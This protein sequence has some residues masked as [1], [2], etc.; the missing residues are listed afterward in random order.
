MAIHTFSLSEGTD[1]FSGTTLGVMSNL[2]ARV[3]DLIRFIG[4]SPT[5]FHATVSLTERLETRGFTRLLM[6]D[7]WEELPAQ[8]FVVVDGS[9]IAWRTPRRWSSASTGLRIIASHTDSPALKVKPNAGF[10][11][12]DSHQVGVEVY[13]GPQLHTWIDRDLCLAGR[14]VDID[15]QVH[16][17]HTQAFARVP[18]LAIHLDRGQR[19]NFHID[20]A[21]DINVLISQVTA[22]NGPIESVAS[23]VEPDRIAGHDL[24]F[25]PSEAP[26][27]LGLGAEYLASYRQDNL[28]SVH[29]GLLGFLAAERSDAVQ[30]YAAFDHEEIGS[31]TVTGASGSLL[32]HVL[33]R[34]SAGFGASMD[35]H[36]AWLARGVAVSADVAHGIHPSRPDV[37]DPMAHAVLNGG[38][39]LKVNAQQRYATD[40]TTAA[41]WTIACRDAKVPVQTYA[42]NSNI[43]GGSS[44][45]PLMA[46]RLGV[47]TVDVGVPVL[48]MHSVRE[49]C[50]IGDQKLFARAVEFFLAG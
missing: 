48:G 4:A 16:M 20:V 50:G 33:R 21:R 22:E 23:G 38:P 1:I 9:V 10:D 42:N 3:Q 18:G 2:D 26:A 37:H 39:V 32:E 6:T 45:G 49:L 30:V 14:V 15:G 29:A 40:A 31:G 28:L 11:R 17:V 13:G 36:L 8:G 12:F 43:L 25:V 35:A 44:L 41:A 24:F 46:M 19:E 27:V 47:R 34:L 7:P 5:S